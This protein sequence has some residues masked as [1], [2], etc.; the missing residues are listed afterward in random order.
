MKAEEFND[1]AFDSGN[2]TF[3]FDAEIQD[4]SCD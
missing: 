3:A 2:W 4:N 1:L